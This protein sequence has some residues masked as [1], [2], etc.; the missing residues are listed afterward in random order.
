MEKLTR[1]N[2]EDL[3]QNHKPATRLP[4]K[5]LKPLEMQREFV[6]QLNADYVLHAVNMYPL[7]IQGLMAVNGAS[8]DP[9]MAHLAGTLLE[10]AGEAE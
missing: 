5:D 8:E 4:W 6:R 2:Y 1:K 3:V 7:L 9:E 10:L